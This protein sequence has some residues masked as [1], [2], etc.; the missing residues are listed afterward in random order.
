MR[1]LAFVRAAARWDNWYDSKIP[2][3]FVCMYYAALSRSTL[4]ISVLGEMAG[5]VAIFCVY[6]AFGHIVNSYSDRSMDI[7][8][9]KP[10]VLASIT[11]R[12]A[13]AMVWFTAIAGLVLIFLLYR[14]RPMVQAL[15]YFSFA[16]AAFYSLPPVRFKERILLGPLTAALAQRTLPAIAVFQ[17][18]GG[19]NWTAIAVC[20][21]STLIGCR[22]I[23]IHQIRDCEAD[24]RAGIRTAATVL[25]ADGLRRLTERL[26]FPLEAAS[27]CITVALMSMELPPVGLMAAAYVLWLFLRKGWEP[28][29]KRRLSPLSYQLL[30]DFYFVYWPLLLAA[31]LAGRNI[32]FLT[33]LLFNLIWQSRMLRTEARHAGSTLTAMRRQFAG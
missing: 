19:W 32:L 30:A 21:L 33:V 7:A 14:D 10:N 11:G 23:V 22:Y 16:L 28:E 1:N 8:A 2:L 5:L 4:N 12:R 9:G 29:A 18:M 20:V 3:F 24:T 17:A 13:Q 25:G 6:A 15:L 26:V 27:L 31:L